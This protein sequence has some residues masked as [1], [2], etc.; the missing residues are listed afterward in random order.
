[1]LVT[2]SIEKEGLKGIVVSICIVVVYLYVSICVYLYVC[3]YMCV[4]MCVS[5]CVY[6]YVCIYVCI[7]VC[8]SH[9]LHPLCPHHRKATRLQDPLLRAQGLV[10][11][12]VV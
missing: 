11:L 10:E 1:V 12:R 7:Y 2:Y 9:L 5:K 4:S 3:I 6:L 8:V